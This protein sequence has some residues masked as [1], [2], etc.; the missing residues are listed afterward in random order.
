M[1]PARWLYHFQ[2]QLHPLLWVRFIFVTGQNQKV[3][4]IPPSV[5]ALLVEA[6]YLFRNTFPCA[7]HRHREAD[8]DSSPS[9]TA[10]FLLVSRLWVQFNRNNKSESLY[11]QF[12]CPQRNL[13]QISWIP[14]GYKQVG[15]YGEAWL[16][17][18]A[19]WDIALIYSLSPSC[20]T[21]K[22]IWGDN[23][24]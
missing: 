16:L 14:K 8:I 15:S 11:I 5:E 9:L 24:L 12:P 10:T 19:L 13:L 4:H 17:K 21:Y 23:P 2:K 20:D 1:V 22:Q 18:Y 3:V 6:A 7:A